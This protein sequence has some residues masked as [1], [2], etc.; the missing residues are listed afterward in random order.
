MF[1]P[2]VRFQIKNDEEEIEKSMHKFFK[3]EPKYNS[4]QRSSKVSLV[5]QSSRQPILSD[6][7]FETAR[8]LFRQDKTGDINDNGQNALKSNAQL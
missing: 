6:N 5:H 2:E 4:N 8:S 3:D 1:P 7:D